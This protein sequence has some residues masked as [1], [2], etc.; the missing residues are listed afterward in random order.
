M[1]DPD[2]RTDSALVVAARHG[3]ELA[4]TQLVARYLR[5][6]MAV[7]IEFT[8]SREDA[9]DVVQEAFRS[10]FQALDRFD[11]DRAFGAWFLTIVR[12]AARS[13]VGSAWSRR[14]ETIEDSLAG[15]A[16]TPLELVGDSELKTAIASALDQ[17][18]PM[19]RT[20][21]QLC[22]VEGLT[23]VEAASAVGLAESTVRVH[24]FKARQRLQPLLAPWRADVEM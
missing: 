8:G 3:E 4:Y 18:P 12:N 11:S 22:V 7:A 17:L 6:A 21:F 2:G 14:R 13:S 24:V 5:K 16:R 1:T 23:S 20:C 10:A 15:A 19:Q 9:E